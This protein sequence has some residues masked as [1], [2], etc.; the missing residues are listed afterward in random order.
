MKCNSLTT[1][2]PFSWKKSIKENLNN[3]DIS[4]ISPE[5]HLCINSVLKPISKI[6]NT[7]IYLR[8]INKLTKTQTS[9]E[10]WVNIFPFLDTQ[11]WNSI[12]K[13]IFTVT[14]EPYL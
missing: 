11:D 3:I 7:Q 2:I 8:L 4:K 14:N 10:T 13:T 9:I 12:Y 6:K 1:A 5:P